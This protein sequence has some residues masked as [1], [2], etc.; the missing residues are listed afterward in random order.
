M[1][2]TEAISTTRTLIR[3]RLP[4]MYSIIVA[5]LF[6]KKTGDDHGTDGQYTGNDQYHIE[7]HGVAGI[8]D[9]A[10]D[11]AYND[12]RNLVERHYPVGQRRAFEEAQEGEDQADGH[13]PDGAKC[14]VFQKN[15]CFHIRVLFSVKI[16][17]FW[18]PP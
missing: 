7:F 11:D 12:D 4:V 15:C 13:D 10:N 3:R 9:V 1:M 5:F 2:P 18:L 17:F 16:Q 14:R 6:V 8:N